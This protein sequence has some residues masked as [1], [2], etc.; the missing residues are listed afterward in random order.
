MS[1]SDMVNGCCR[2]S[3][4]FFSTTDEPCSDRRLI[5]KAMVMGC[6]SGP[7]MR[8]ATSSGV[9]PMT[10]TPSTLSSTSPL[11]ISHESAAGPP[12]MT[13]RTKSSF[14]SFVLILHPIPAL[15]SEDTGGD[16]ALF[17]PPPSH[18]PAPP[19]LPWLPAVGGL[20]DI[21]NPQQLPPSVLTLDVA[22]KDPQPLHTLRIRRDARI[23][24][25]LPAASLRTATQWCPP[26]PQHA[27]AAPAGLCSRATLSS[28]P[29]RRRV[30]DGRSLWA[31]HSASQ[32]PTTNTHQHS[33][34]CLPSALSLSLRTGR[35]LGLQAAE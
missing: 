11:A 1:R 5:R 15:R 2:T 13:S 31:G 26:T 23:E 34:C 28:S 16:G 6:P 8:R 33:R 20:I 4:T 14:L 18:I 9:S 17:P 10:M 32:P 29:W 19:R 12:G 25:H 24:I 7:T 27:A 21:L 35:S 30:V 3:V 22:P